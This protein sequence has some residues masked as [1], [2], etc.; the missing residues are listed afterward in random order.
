L[1]SMS[2]G[3]WRGVS[4]GAERALERSEAGARFL[5]GL[6]PPSGTADPE[7]RAAGLLVALGSGVGGLRWCRQV[8]GRTLASLSAELGRPLK[9]AACV[10]R[11]DGLLSA[12]AGLALVVW[13][14]DCVP[15]LMAGGGVVGAVHAGW[16]GAAAGVVSAAVRRFQVEYGVSS[17]R[18]TVALGPAVGACHYEVGRE[19]VDALARVGVERRR[20]LR[21][22]RVDLRGFLVG[23]LEG[24]GV[25]PE[26]VDVVGGCTACDQGL[27]SYRR[28]GGRA[29]RQWSLV[30]RSDPSP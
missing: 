19:V 25:R 26:A 28:D 9:E 14:A 24:L 11:C 16:R 30:V 23:E 15:V 4:L 29:G 2:D 21:S 3:R 27:S 7:G 20:W 17:D 1:T 8:H 18:L 6:G 22:P 12:D 5:F 13:T 10:G